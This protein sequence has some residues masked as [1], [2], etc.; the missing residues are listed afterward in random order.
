MLNSGKERGGG[1]VEVKGK[2][3][4]AITCEIIASSCFSFFI[5]ERE[6]TVDR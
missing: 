2:R 1:E 4:D 5:I 3:D 6:R